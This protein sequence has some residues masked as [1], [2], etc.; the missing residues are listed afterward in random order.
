MND[1]L[2][3]QG[4]IND[5]ITAQKRHKEQLAAMK[6]SEARITHAIANFQRY[7]D[8]RISK[9]EVVN[10]I[11]KVS[12]PDIQDVVS[13]IHDL[14]VKQDFAPVIASLDEL[15]KE[16]AC[17]PEKM[18][19][20]EEKEIDLSGFGK[21]EKAIQTLKLPT[22][23]VNIDAPKPIDLSKLETGIA[24]VTKAVKGL[25]LPETDLTNVEKKL[26]TSNKLLKEIVDKPVGGGGGGGN[27]TP[28]IDST[29]KPMNVQLTAE[30][31]IPVESGASSNYESRNDT[32]TDSNLVYL[33]KATPGTAGSS[34]GWQI[35]CYNKSAGTMTFADDETSFTKIWADRATYNY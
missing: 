17:L 9:T 8:G 7:L 4:I 35:K 10:Q 5:K 14:D 18:P 26:D 11:E 28:Y 25:K 29:G 23:Q 12:T 19:K 15:K 31:K 2:R 24:D 34:A 32:T 22:P 6:D 33:G 3:L 20:L 13:A 1:K 30:G 21:L 16:I 27:G